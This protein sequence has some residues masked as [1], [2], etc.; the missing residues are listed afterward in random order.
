MLEFKLML[1]T[2][3]TGW[4]EYPRQFWL[5]F[6]G[7][8][9][10]TIG[11]SMIWPFLTIY[12]SGKLHQPLVTVTTLMTLNSAVGLVMNFVAGPITDRFGR[13]WVLVFALIGNS[14]VYLIQNQAST[15]GGFALA[16]CLS[17]AF[18]PMYRVAS[19]AMMADL[20]PKEKRADAY[21]LMRMSNNVGVALGPT[22]GGF[23]AAQSYTMAFYIA[24]AGMF[25]YGM[26]QAFGSKETLNREMI[27]VD[28]NTARPL[29]GGYSTIF[30]DRS[31]ISTILAYTF[32]MT[33]SAILWLLMAVYVKTNYGIN[34]NLYGFIP[35]TNALMVVF[36]QIFVTKFT[37]RHNPLHMMAMG[38]A[39]Y[40]V[41]VGSV[42]FARG[43][44]AFWLSM[45]IIT[46][47]ELIVVPTTTTYVANKAPS[48][49]RGRY[50]S[51]YNLSAGVAQ[52]IGPLA[53]GFVGDRFGQRNIWPAAFFI[54]LWSPILFMLQARRQT[55]AEDLPSQDQG[56]VQA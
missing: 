25:T 1:N 48:H 46:I 37:S 35:A 6:F 29:G 13:K 7:M 16:L 9:I 5:M 28:E 3:R 33:G 43:F 41:G 55:R 39:F 30:A 49:L 12:I 18:N 34:E 21:S 22:I 17:G 24:A 36:L 26:I 2:F 15:F 11:S 40:A 50:M 10:S 45:V 52:G 8:L 44:W 19:D 14:V 20:I 31:F 47:G 4:R 42:F 32:C 38:A 53:G 56:A 54:G 23:I 27:P 51:I